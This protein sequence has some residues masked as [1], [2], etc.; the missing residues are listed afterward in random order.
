MAILDSTVT[1]NVLLIL[2]IA[3]YLFG[4]KLIDA[5]STK[6]GQNIADKE[7]A[8]DIES[9]KREGGLPYD[10]DLEKFKAQSSYVIE[11]F[12][13]SLKIR[14]ETKRKLYDGLVQ[15]KTHTRKFYH[16]SAGVEQLQNSFNNF[17]NCLDE[18][19]DFMSCN[20]HFIAEID[21]SFLLDFENQ[22]NEYIQCF[23]EANDSLNQG[24]LN[25]VL[26]DKRAKSAEKLLDLIDIY[27]GKI[28]Q[29]NP[30][31]LPYNKSLKQDK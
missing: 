3:W 29:I 16:R 22:A 19:S 4:K 11:E 26:L 8:K 10:I 2:Y 28:F 20:K 31:E 6:K 5:Y 24:E 9:Q 12:K 30:S 13:E 15:L 27:L 14:I 25:N 7:D 17:T 21:N 1:T 18:I 23:K